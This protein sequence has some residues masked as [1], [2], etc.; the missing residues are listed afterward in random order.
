MPNA[1]FASGLL[2]GFHSTVAEERARKDKN[3]LAAAQFL[4][5]TGMARD[6]NDV[7]PLIG[8][9]LDGSGV[10]P[11]G[12]PR[13]GKRG[14]KSAGGKGGGGITDLLAQ[15]INPAL[16]GGAG[17]EGGTGKPP[18][19]FSAEEAQQGAIGG[20]VQTEDVLFRTRM[21]RAEQ[22][23]Q[24]GMPRREA[25]KLVGLPAPEPVLAPPS[26]SVLEETPTGGYKVGV[27]TPARPEAAAN[28]QKGDRLVEG[29]V[30]SLSYDP[31]SGQWVDVAGELGTPGRVVL[32]STPVPSERAPQRARFAL[33]SQVNPDGTTSL[34]K[35]NLDTNEVVDLT[36]STPGGQLGLTSAARDRQAAR[37]A[38]RPGFDAI[39]ELG[40]RVI[41][42]I[43]PAQRADAIK[44][45]TAAVLGEDPEW[46]TYRDSRMAL[47]A[48]LAV[49]QQGSRPSD[50]D[51][52]AVWLPLIPDVFADTTESAAMKWQM[53]DTM[54]Q[55]P[56]RSVQKSPPMIR[57]R[58]PGGQEKDV[59]AADVPAYRAKGAVI[60]APQ[61]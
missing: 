48:N 45:G 51:V 20:A 1:A 7:L 24:G 38:L 3:N 17:A 2:E 54:L 52:A 11:M 40:A 43:G 56:P 19:L 46:R 6:L 59:P 9:T 34:V 28:L 23:I 26:A 33:Q 58:A 16:Q 55:L 13:G 44:R 21:A 4:L 36:P 53:I 18:L 29:R 47:A 5:Q 8:E 12:M 25:L 15:M 22:L 39:K 14:G 42:K 50:K 60:V 49:A 61:K 30:V 57:M 31:D 41:T 10:G 27:T 35:V 37:L 32:G